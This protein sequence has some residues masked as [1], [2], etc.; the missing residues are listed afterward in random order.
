MEMPPKHPIRAGAVSSL[1]V[2][3][4]MTIA[5]M[6][7]GTAAAQSLGEPIGQVDRVQETVTAELA[8]DIRNLEVEAPIRFGEVLRS[9]PA[10]RLQA[11]LID[12][13]EITLGAN[14]VLT[15]D[16]FV[17]TPQTQGGSLA[18]SVTDGAFLFVGG[19]VE[20]PSGGNVTIETPVGTLGIRGTTVWGGPLD[21]AYSI[22]TIEGEVT[23][24]NSGGSV[25]LTDGMG[26]TVADAA[27]APEEPSLWTE[28]RLNRAVATITFAP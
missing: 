19:Q 5:G 28:T 17:Y 4:S 15:I 25:T 27:T 16:E 1:V 12:E 20:D 18:M 22:I 13:T 6:T 11:T 9:W 2:A 7:A 21:D 8:E 3:L 24:T 14:A 10:A 23:V 26:T